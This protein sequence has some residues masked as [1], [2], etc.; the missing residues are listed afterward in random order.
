MELALRRSRGDVEQFGD[1]AVLVTLDVVQNEDLAGARGQPLDEVVEVHAQIS[2]GRRYCGEVERCRVVGD[3]SALDG[4]R[5]TPFDH[6]VQRQPVQPCAERRVSPEGAQLLPGP[7]EDVLGYFVGVIAAEHPPGQAM[8]PGDMA[9]IETL[10]R[11]CVAGD[12][13]GY[14]GV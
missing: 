14:V 11:G 7:D 12:R 5:S 1:F 2:A 3:S 4:E 13:A 6:H 8:D 10:E 9:A